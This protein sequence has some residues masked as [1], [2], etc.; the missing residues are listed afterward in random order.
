M[1]V[2]DWI[3]LRLYRLRDAW[4]SVQVEFHGRYSVER[5]QQLKAFAATLTTSRIVVICLLTPLPCLLLALLIESAP[6]AP[7][8]DGIATNWVFLLRFGTITCIMSGSMVYQLGVNIP[9]LGVRRRNIATNGILSGVAASATLYA[10]ASSV[11][12]PVPFSMLLASPP[13]VVVFIVCFATFWGAQLKADPSINVEMD[14]NMTILNC[15]LSLTLIY[16]LYIFGFTSLTGIRQTAFVLVLPVIKLVAKNWISRALADQNDLKPE[17]V[18]FNVEVFNALYIAAAL[19]NASSWM[20]TAAVMAIDILHFWVSMRDVV[21]ILDD[22]KTLMNKIP[23]SHSIAKENFMQIALRMMAIETERMAHTD[24]HSDRSSSAWASRIDTWVGPSPVIPSKVNVKRAARSAS[25]RKSS[26]IWSHAR[27]SSSKAQVFP[28]RPPKRQRWSH[29]KVN[30]FSRSTMVEELKAVMRE[31]DTL[32]IETIFTSK[33][34]A[35]FIQKSAR[36]LFI[37]EYIIL[38]EYVEVV[39]PLVY[40]LHRAILYN[41]HN[42]AY[43]PTLAKLSS[44]QLATTTLNVLIYGS[45][46]LASL[47]A[48]FFVL[49]HYLGFSSVRQLAFVLQTQADVIQAKILILFIYIMQIS[50]IHLGADFSFKFAWLRSTSSP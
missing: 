10:V 20:S 38:V 16:S 48:S 22:V 26:D 11:V 50:L 7:P 1:G 32:G 27:V 46:E 4:F 18:V 34:R 28:I 5:L 24:N 6:L 19:Q 14:R 37:A 47:V 8:D 40:S 45:L 44:A 9:Q 39:L 33:E 13:S 3:W 43:Y 30:P 12:F 29:V 49:R 41:L 23:Q 35:E 17:A 42:G 15:Q 21:E 2:V 25:K 36:I 31:G